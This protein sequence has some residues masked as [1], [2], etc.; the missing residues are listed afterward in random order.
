MDEVGVDSLLPPPL[1]YTTALPLAVR[2]FIP[3][4]AAPF[5]RI[6]LPPLILYTGLR[7]QLYPKAWLP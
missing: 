2:L 5:V 7:P 6:R 1:I 3:R 4:I